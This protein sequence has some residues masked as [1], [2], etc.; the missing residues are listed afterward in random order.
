[1]INRYAIWIFGLCWI[2]PFVGWA[3]SP[4]PDI[5][6]VQPDVS[7][8]SMEEGPPAPGKRVK[9]TASEFAGTD[10]HHSLYLPSDWAPGQ[11]FP[12][13]VE[14]AG[15]GPYR[16]QFGDTCSGKVEDCNLGFGISGGEGFIWLCLPYISPDGQ[17]NQLQ[18]WGD[19]DATVEYCKRE[20]DRVCEQFGGDRDRVLICGFSRG[21]I[22]CNFIGLHDDEI[23]SIWCGFI[24]HSHYDGLP[25]RNYPKIDPP[26]AAE[27]LSRLGDRPQFIS[28]EGSV[29]EVQQYLRDR[30]GDFTFL[31]LPYR[32]HTD[33]W[34]LRDIPEREQLRQ[35][36]R[37]KIK[38]G[39]GHG[40]KRELNPQQN[41]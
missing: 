37:E 40:K 31:R 29:A 6:T 36:V 24:C 17:R 11:T 9:I 38:K 34:V 19:V 30:P 25:S 8:P 32:N 20:V 26:S 1:M 2:V 14:Y 13:I 15:N 28:H 35:W 33:T 41:R 5:R 39:A 16:N 22:A 23:S 3:Q 4:L 10:V 18:W 12:V 27:R 21:S 7:T